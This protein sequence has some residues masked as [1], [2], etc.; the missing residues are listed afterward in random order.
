MSAQPLPSP[1][2]RCHCKLN[3][4]TDAGQRP[5]STL[6]GH[7]TVGVPPIAGPTVGAQ[8][9]PQTVALSCARPDLTFNLVLNPP[10]WVGAN[11]RSIVQLSPAA[12]A[13][14]QPVAENGAPR[15]IVGRAASS[16][17]VLSTVTLSVLNAEG[18]VCGKATGSPVMTIVAGRA[19]TAPPSHAP[20]SGRDTSRWSVDSF[21]HSVSAVGMTSSAGLP[22]CSIIVSVGPP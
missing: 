8:P 6:V 20:F 11:L 7:P 19:P 16:S 4:A 10:P 9:T 17:P 13:P 21:V 22:A 1:S 3:V 18:S 15:V 12:I 2:H 5:V 14:V